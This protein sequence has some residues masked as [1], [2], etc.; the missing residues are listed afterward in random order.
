MASSQTAGVEGER[1][2]GLVWARV[3]LAA[4]RLGVGVTNRGGS[5]VNNGN[6]FDD[7]GRLNP[8]TS[9]PVHTRSQPKPTDLD[10]AALMGFSPAKGTHEIN[11][12]VFFYKQNNNN[13]NNNFYY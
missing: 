6:K 4:E 8:V 1:N 3:L 12:I 2:G 10:R 11:H 9:K 7:M 5:N 13:N